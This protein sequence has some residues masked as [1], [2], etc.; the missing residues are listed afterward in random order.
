MA[1]FAS[2]EYFLLPGVFHGN[3]AVSACNWNF[4]ISELYLV[5]GWKTFCKRNLVLS[6]IVGIGSCLSSDKIRVRGRQWK[7]FRSE[8][9][10]LREEE[11]WGE[12]SVCIT[13]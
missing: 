7:R 10:I 11:C 6:S 13:K 3:H 9:S 5:S 2:D 4:F 1:V 12:L 8:D